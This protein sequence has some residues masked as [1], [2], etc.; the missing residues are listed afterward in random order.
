MTS[1]QLSSSSESERDSGTI[2]SMGFGGGGGRIEE[3][4]VVA[5][6]EEPGR[7][8]GEGG[9][10]GGGA[11][12]ACLAGFAGLGFAGTGA[13]VSRSTGGGGPFSTRCERFLPELLPMIARGLDVGSGGD[14]LLDEAVEDGNAGVGAGA[15]LAR[16][17]GS[18]FVGRLFASGLFGDGK[19]SSSSSSSSRLDTVLD[20]QAKSASSS[21]RMSNWGGSGTGVETGGV[22]NEEVEVSRL[23]KGITHVVHARDDLAGIMEDKLLSDVSWRHPSSFSRVKVP[24]SSS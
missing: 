15:G 3:G 6:D 21:S 19:S 9:G 14:G 2:S 4:R 5:A 20:D 23:R 1:S 17:F 12:G 11:A 18:G 16:A 8:R 7:A 13:G 24:V 10:R 22:A